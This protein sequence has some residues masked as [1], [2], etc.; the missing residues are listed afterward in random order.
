MLN[1]GNEIAV[2]EKKKIFRDFFNKHNHSYVWR[3]KWNTVNCKS[4][5]CQLVHVKRHTY[6]ILSNVQS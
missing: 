5:Y 4:Q 1:E 3:F 6:G 2:H